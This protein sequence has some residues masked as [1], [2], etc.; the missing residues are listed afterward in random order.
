M[1]TLFEGQ[2]YAERYWLVQAD[3][4]EDGRISVS[5]KASKGTK[6]RLNQTT[7]WSNGAWDLSEEWIPK[8]PAPVP[9]FIL[10]A[11]VNGL[12]ELETSAN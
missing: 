4:G 12:Q 5:F 1:I 9:D 2:D 11:V 3:I 7:A 10:R 6:V 8:T